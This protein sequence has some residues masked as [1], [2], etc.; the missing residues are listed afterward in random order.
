[1]SKLDDFLERYDRRLDW[2][3][4]NGHPVLACVMW[5]VPLFVFIASMALALIALFLFAANTKPL[6]WLAAAVGYVVFLFVRA[7]YASSGVE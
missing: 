4:A 5:L 6:M 2:L 1:M 7:L 3:D